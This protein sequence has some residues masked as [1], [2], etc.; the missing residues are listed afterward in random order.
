MRIGQ[1]L[2]SPRTDAT[3][4]FLFSEQRRRES[5]VWVLSLRVVVVVVWGYDGM[6]VQVWFKSIFFKLGDGRLLP[7]LH[8][9][10]SSPRG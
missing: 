2:A 8:S 3:A 1:G 6:D 7:E 9:S 4:V 10:P 5:F